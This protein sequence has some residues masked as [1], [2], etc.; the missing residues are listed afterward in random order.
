MNPAIIGKLAGVK[1]YIYATLII[2]IIV[3]A[4]Y[5][6][7]FRTGKDQGSTTIEQVPLPDDVTESGVQLTTEEATKVRTISKELHADMDGW[8]AFSHDME[9]YRNLVNLSDTLFVAVYNDFNTLYAESGET[10]RQWI[11]G[12]SFVTFGLQSV[13]MEVR[14]NILDRMNRLNL[15]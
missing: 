10:L 1:M 2:L 8:N 14:Q 5:W 6:F 9:P 15:Q 12:E 4:I 7:A 13:F 3:V 11:E